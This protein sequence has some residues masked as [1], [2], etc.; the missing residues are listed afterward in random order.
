MALKRTLATVPNKK[1]NKFVL[2]INWM[3]GDADASTRSEI[4]YD[5]EK[6]LEKAITGIQVLFKHYKASWNAMCDANNNKSLAQ[7]EEGFRRHQYYG[8]AIEIYKALG[9]NHLSEYLESFGIEHEMD[10]QY[11]GG[12]LCFVDSIEAEYFDENGVKYLLDIKGAKS[13]WG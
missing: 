9:V 11:G 6:E 10:N 8:E 12:Y 2:I 7:L 13:R 1:K 4:I 5:T 3:H